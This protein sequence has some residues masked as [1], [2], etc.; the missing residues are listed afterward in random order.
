MEDE[1]RYPGQSTEVFPEPFNKPPDVIPTGK[2]GQLSEEK[3]RQFFDEVSI[4]YRTE[5]AFTYPHNIGYM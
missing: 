5:V 4:V 1:K 3:I 2:P